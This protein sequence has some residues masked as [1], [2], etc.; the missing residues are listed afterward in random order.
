MLDAREALLRD[1]D[2][3]RR[4]AGADFAAA[5]RDEMQDFVAAYTERKQRAGKA[6]FPGPAAAGAQPGARQREVRNYLQHASRA[7]SWTNFR[8]P[9]RCR[10]KS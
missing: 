9:I 6:R 4:D 8:T 5:L 2:A 7:S 1:L 3:F 10:P